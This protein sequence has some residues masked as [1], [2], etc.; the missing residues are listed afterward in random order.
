[1]TSLAGKVALVTGASRGIGAAIAAAYAGAG[2]KLVL[3]ARKEAG[4]E[5]VRA[6]IGGADVLAVPCH[7]GKAD[8]VRA[9]VARGIERFGK[10]DVLVNNAAT[11]VHFGPLVTVDDAAWD[12]I[13][14]VNLKGAF[15]AAR[16]VAEHLVERGSPGSI[17]NIASIMGMRAAPL[18]GVYGMTKAALISMTQ[19]L[20]AELGSGGIRVNAIA[21]GLVDTRFAKALLDDDTLMTEYR[22]HTSLA[23]AGKPEEIAG[24]ALYL[25]SDA[26]SYVTGQV[27]TVDGGYTS[28]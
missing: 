23:R 27:L 1:V 19:T 21:P 11:N 7:V 9:L 28:R 26:A 17:I 15:A 10:I 16:A 2:A 14:E 22:A 4:L 13:F 18:Q 8:E 12:K 20:A 6:R 5:E 3:A 25:A 24:A